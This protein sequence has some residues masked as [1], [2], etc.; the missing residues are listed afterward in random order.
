MV[1]VIKWDGRS[2]EFDSM[3]IVRTLTRMGAPQAVAEEIAEELEDRVEEGMATKEIYD[4]AVTELE[5]HREVVEFRRDLRD[6]L[7]RIGSG[8]IFEDY[9]RLLLEEY[10]Y[11]VSGNVVLQGACVDHEVDSIAER[12]G[13]VIYVEM[14]HHSVLERYTPFEVTL[15]AK[16][17]WDDLQAGCEQGLND[18]S[19]D[20]VLIVTNTRLTQHARHYAECVGI[21][22]FGWNTPIGRGIDWFIENKKLY[23]VTILRTVTDEERDELYKHRILTLNQL[24]KADPKSVGLSETRLK[25][26]IAETQRVFSCCQADA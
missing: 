20:R 26:L 7:A 18:C 5:T 2:E 1:M 17:K 24:M 23:P 9:V 11:K 12:D 4:M 16:A 3:K 21:E 25:E 10:G 6:G 8:F 22:H 14:K 19:F 15:A 13:E